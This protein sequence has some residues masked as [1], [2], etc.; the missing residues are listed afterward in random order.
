MR[1]LITSITMRERYT[2]NQAS[3]NFSF[4]LQL[5]SSCGL[6]GSS[7]Q[8]TGFF[9]LRTSL[10]DHRMATRIA[11]CDADPNQSPIDARSIHQDESN[12]TVM[13]EMSEVVIG[14]GSN[15]AKD[16]IWSGVRH[17]HGGT[18]LY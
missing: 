2:L 10:L 18:L 7:S 14:V 8:S 15:A 16:T 17:M 12:G 5:S 1:N 4:V 11:I 13:D 6:A 3:S 9:S